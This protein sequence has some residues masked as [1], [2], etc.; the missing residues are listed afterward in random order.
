MIETLSD[1]VGIEQRGRT[2]FLWC[3]N[4]PVNAVNGAIRSGLC[5]G[6]ERAGENQAIDAV[7]I[8]CR[9]RSFFTGAD[10]TEFGKAID[11]PSW[12]ATDAAIEGSKKPVIAAIHGSCLGGGLEY[13]LACHH[14][15]ALGD[16]K[17]G[18]P[19]VKLGLLPGGGGTQ[20]FP[21][22]A[23]FEAALEFIPSGQTFGAQRALE[24]GVLDRIVEAVLDQAAA[25]FAAEIAGRPG[26]RRR[27]RDRVDRIEAAK[28]DG[29]RLFLEARNN[30][31]RRYPG[32]QS[33]LRAIAAIEDAL[34]LPFD[35]G[36]NSE[37]RLFEECQSSAEHRGLAHL[38]FAERRAR[39]V[40]GLS[41]KN[42][43]TLDRVAVIGGG[44]MG[45]GIAL[46]FSAAQIPVTLV[47]ID[48]VAV[49]RAR[50]R[51]GDELARAVE[52]S[53]MTAEQ[54][55][56]QLD[57]IDL[58]SDIASANGANLV[59][60]AVHESM[61]IKQQVFS[62][63]DLVMQPGA[64]LASN[65]SNLNLDD[66]ARVTRRP[67]SVVGLH[68]FSPANVMQLLEIVR[69][70]ETSDSV[71]GAAL[72]IAK[73]LGK[74]PV[75]ARVCD[76]FITNRIFGEYW[77][78]SRFMVEEGASPYEVDKVLVS[79]GMPMGPFAVSD[80]VGLDVSKMIREN[81]RAVVGPDDRPDTIEDE[82]VMAGRLGR[83]NELGWYRYS[84]GGRMGEP[85]P[86]LL[87]TVENHRRKL[88]RASR[89]ISP[90]E[91]IARCLFG[92]INEGAKTVEEGVA[93]RASDV[94]VAAVYG[95]GFPRYRGGPM[96][97]ADE[98]GLRDIATTVQSLH[99]SQGSRWQ[100]ARLLLELARHSGRLAEA[101]APE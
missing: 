77:R 38:F 94:D 39:N 33:P 13:A 72:E 16:T 88:G 69:G 55:S 51:I 79:F 34:H 83:K 92:V 20:R 10:I 98:F 2:T 22:L 57:R 96:H 89:S 31:E 5:R 32:R 54:A 17:F 21:R 82:L 49:A 50:R 24:L 70:K 53:R 15:I 97:Y 41:A 46:A 76:G 73:R 29:P 58:A 12:K 27:V 8:I 26:D 9:G 47:D 68:F 99:K 75:V 1:A 61:P 45:C 86:E 90:D 91:I 44:T 81:R 100:P 84:E 18:F 42:P 66:I 25:R 101:V 63:L 36:M 80:L 7:V 40:P 6:L 93:M 56:A 85:D 11:A 59:I 19:E 64:I 67:Q 28:A 95:Y 3:D 71:L 48:E 23:G 14:R 35:Q 30:A 37:A 78:Q 65:T 43:L 74:Q 62:H 52:R 87:V 4:P 60:E